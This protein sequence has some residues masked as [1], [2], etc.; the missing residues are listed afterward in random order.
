M[1]TRWCPVVKGDCQRDCQFRLYHGC[2]ISSVLFD[3]GLFYEECG[4]YVYEQRKRD[5]P[6][7]AEPTPTEVPDIFKKAFRKRKTDK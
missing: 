1:K 7:L 3:I 2:V 4:H 5:F 6:Q